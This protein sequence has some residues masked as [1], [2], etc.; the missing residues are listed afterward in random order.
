MVN[1]NHDHCIKSV[2]IIMLSHDH[3]FKLSQTI[4]VMTNIHGQIKF[5][6]ILIKISNHFSHDNYSGSNQGH[7]HY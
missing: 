4:L 6:T 7:D 5:M 3:H 2:M 1:A